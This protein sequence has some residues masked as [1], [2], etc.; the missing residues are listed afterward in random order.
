MVNTHMVLYCLCLLNQLLLL[1]IM[2]IYW[3]EYNII[4]PMHQILLMLLAILILVYHAGK[5]VLGKLHNELNAPITI[6]L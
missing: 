1:M 3:Q 6:T 2:H 5:Y 4:Y